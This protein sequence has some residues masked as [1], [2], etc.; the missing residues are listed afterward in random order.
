[1]TRNDVLEALLTR[2]ADVCFRDRNGST[3][4]HWAA[5]TGNWK[6]T[7]LLLQHNADPN[8][9]DLDGMTPLH[10]A[11]KN[12]SAADVRQLA[13]VMTD[14]NSLAIHN[15]R[16]V[17]ALYLAEQNGFRHIAEYLRER[18]A[19]STAQAGIVAK[20]VV[21]RTVSAASS[22]LE[23][24][25]R[26]NEFILAARNNDIDKMRKMRKHGIDIESKHSKDESTALHNAAYY[27][28]V[29][30]LRW[31]LS[32]G[33]NVNS[34]D[35]LGRTPLFE[36]CT[37]NGLRAV[38]VLLDHGADPDALDNNATRPFDA[39]SNEKIRRLL[40]ERSAIRYD[41]ECLSDLHKA[42]RDEDV[43]AVG[44]IVECGDHANQMTFDGDGNTPLHYAAINN[45][46]RIVSKMVIMGIDVDQTN[47]YG[48][49][50]L[51]ATVFRRAFHKAESETSRRIVEMLGWPSFRRDGGLNFVHRI[52]PQWNKIPLHWAAERG[53]LAQVELL[54]SWGSDPN[55]PDEFGETPLHYA[56]EFGHTEVTK[57]LI[58]VTEVRKLDRQGF[59]PLRKARERNK[60]A[61]VSLMLPFWTEADVRATDAQKKSFKDWAIELKL[62]DAEAKVWVNLPCDM[63]EPPVLD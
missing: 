52:G 26:A 24:R 29:N 21:D 2:G 19:E 27:G 60:A 42:V 56:A 12:G 58:P 3:A 13:C 31:L 6:A 54:L 61:T 46:D 4:L 11:C 30:I 37:T 25:R 45:L 8:A 10:L 47:R 1:M 40:R 44:R 57:R 14:L 18:N 23:D 62:Y 35:F 55:R 28:H 59:T 50:A 43:D 32:L 63:E 16:G 33:A 17:T 38:D 22:K 34:R 48:Q 15:D 5:K 49:T 20:P 39:T 7:K 53:K 51:D 41:P 36:A 9:P